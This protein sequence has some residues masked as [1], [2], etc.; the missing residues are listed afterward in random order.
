[1]DTLKSLK[2]SVLVKERTYKKQKNWRDKN[3]SMDYFRCSFQL[4]TNYHH[5]CIT[6]KEEG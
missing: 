5:N 1:M 4:S 6:E 2:S 3:G